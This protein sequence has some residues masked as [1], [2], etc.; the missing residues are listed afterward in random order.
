MDCIN[1]LRYSS[2]ISNT[3]SLPLSADFPNLLIPILKKK[4]WVEIQVGVMMLSRKINQILS[5]LPTSMLPKVSSR[6]D[7]DPA[8]LAFNAV[9]SVSGSF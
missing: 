5:Q 9:E 3:H 7:A 8:D 6:S 4:T 2:L 1:M